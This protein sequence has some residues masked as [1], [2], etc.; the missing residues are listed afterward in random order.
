MKNNSSYGTDNTYENF[1]AMQTKGRSYIK[2]DCVI[3]SKW[4]NPFFMPKDLE[5]FSALV[6]C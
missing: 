4:F 1:S 5:L 6:K 3:R 2:P